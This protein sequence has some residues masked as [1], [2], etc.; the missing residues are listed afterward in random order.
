M[1]DGVDELE[2][3]SEDERTKILEETAAV[4]ETITK[5]SNVKLY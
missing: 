1:D 5:V 3:L 2:E 4:K